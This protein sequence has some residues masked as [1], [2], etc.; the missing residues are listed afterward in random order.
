MTIN[1]NHLTSLT[2]SPY[3]NQKLSVFW[4]EDLSIRIDFNILKTKL[5]LKKT[6][7]KTSKSF[8]TS[9]NNYLLNMRFS[10]SLMRW[11]LL[12]IMLANER[13]KTYH[14]KI[15]G[16][17]SRWPLILSLIKKTK[18]QAYP[19]TLFSFKVGIIEV[20]VCEKSSCERQTGF[21]NWWE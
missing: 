4:T 10:S 2:D 7:L 5:S 12:L 11:I 19:P 15:S 16:I 17:S 1:S 8:L 20:C 21:P 9:K 18:N 3:Y 14:P 13:T 6:T